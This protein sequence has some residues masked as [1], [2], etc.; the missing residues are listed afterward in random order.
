MKRYLYTHATGMTLLWAA[1]IFG[2]CATPGQY[3]PS[4]GWM[5]LLSI[6]KLVHASVFFIL[7]GLLV[8]VAFKQ[9]ESKGR[10]VLYTLLA[11]AYGAL[12]EFMQ[13]RYFSNRSADAFDIVANSFGCVIALLF[14]RHIRRFFISAG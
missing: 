3:L 13:A 4:A 5:E 10:A 6:D 11:I 9:A 14:S 7:T 12:L 2:L 8:L 1:V